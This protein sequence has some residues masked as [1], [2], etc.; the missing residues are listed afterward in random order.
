LKTTLLIAALALCALVSTNAVAAAHDGSATT[1][2]PA[3][4][5]EAFHAVLAHDAVNAAHGSRSIERAQTKASVSPQQIWTEQDVLAAD[6]AID[7]RFGTAVAV[8]GDIAVIGAADAKVGDNYQQGAAYVF[9]LKSG[10]WTQTQKLLASDGAGMANFGSAVALAGDTILIGAINA[11][12][13]TTSDQGAVYVFTRTDGVWTQT[14]KLASNDGGSGDAFG[15]AL[16]LDGGTALIG[17]KGASVNG[18]TLQGKV[19]VFTCA[20]STWTQA[21]ML[22]ANDGAGN[23]LFGS[24]LAFDGDVAII[25]APTLTYNFLHAGWAY[26]FT[27]TDGI[28][29][30]TQKL[31][32]TTSAV[33][34]QFGYAVGLAGDTALVTSTGNQFAHGAVYVFR[35]GGDGWV[36]TQQLAPADG[37]SG[38][39]FGIVLAM[40]GTG[41]LIGAQ[42]LVLDGHQGAAYLFSATDGSW[43]QTQEFTESAGTT[44]DFF[45]GAVAFDGTTVLIGTP[46]AT[47]DGEQ[48][49]GAASF[50]SASSAGDP[51]IAVTPMSLSSEQS[52][53]TTTT[54]VLTIANSGAA[55]L[56]WSLSETDSQTADCSAPAGLSWLAATPA[57]GSTTPAASTSID[58]SFDSGGLAVG[59]YD[60]VL[61]IA[62]NDPDQAMISVA[63]S[64][65]VTASSTLPEQE[66]VADDGSAGD[67]FGI[68]V[69]IEGDT[70]L[71]GAIYQDAGRGA[72]YVFSQSDGVWSETQKLTAGDG[73]SN[74]WFGQS[75]AM[76]GDT[77]VIGAPQYLDFGSGAAYVFTRSGQTWREAQKLTADDGALR[78]QFGTAVA[79][80]GANVLVGA[81]GAH[82][83][84]GAAYVF[85]GADG[86]WTQTQKLVASDA[87]TNAD[88]A[89][90]VALQDDTAILGAFGDGAYQG[91]AYVFTDTSGTWSQTQKLIA[92]DA[93]PNAHFG[94]SVA[95][96]GDT[97]LIGAEGATVGENS[98]QGAAYAFARTDGSWSQTQE[99]TSSDGAA[100]DYF[101]RSVA[102]DGTQAMIGAYGPNALQG[103][104]YL[105]S[106][107]ED[108]WSQTQAL[109]ASDAAPGAQFG[110]FVALAGSTA[111]VGADG[112][113]AFRGAAYFYALPAQPPTASAA[114]DSLSFALTVGARAESTLTITNTGGGDLVYTLADAQ[115]DCTVPAD[116][117]WLDESPAEGS[118]AAG[119]AQEVTITASAR[120][121]AAG[122]YSAVLCVASNDAHDAL[123]RIPVSLTVA[124]DDVVFKNGFDP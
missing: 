63:V 15:N 67:E 65:S 19:Y 56:S 31:T 92:S 108:D 24:S 38:D 86:S 114:P 107:G 104:A 70:A 95:L 14:Q 122:D 48:F 102:L 10:V 8:S 91:A 44:L 111:V 105:F 113:S 72:V 27:A 17:A 5:R 79:L 30:Q 42:R 7:D 46:G 62:S 82:T 54:Q 60:G 81:Y 66:V 45:G 12:V 112:A 43:S 28:W 77:A 40:S 9:A 50:Y 87:A 110:I 49:Q 109:T 21:E 29:T 93:A 59:E 121:L 116:V 52:A 64:L 68:S 13:G 117:A 25:G 96:D 39:E 47:V 22:L 57:S 98:H 71:I 11:N 118:I 89:V 6:G 34:D 61:C 84:Q 55:D 23:D 51:E 88:F 36:Q 76:Q 4:L 16:A 90:S 94:I 124:E 97:A 74:D 33:G 53:D 103:A 78:D 99:L 3:G 35:N 69:A 101:G 100:W 120:A 80:D 83:Y 20:G 32:P 26:V 2:M 1:S 18:N 115:S 58:V 41:A 73:A 119:A 85:A 37:A 106:R 123:I 75:V